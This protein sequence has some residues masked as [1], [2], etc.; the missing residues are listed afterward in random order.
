MKNFEMNNLGE[1]MTREEMVNTIGGDGEWH[2]D[3]A[4]YCF[5][6]GG[7]IGVVAYTVG[8]MQD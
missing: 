5:A 4:L 2:W 6:I 8:T 1:L 7:V 3:E